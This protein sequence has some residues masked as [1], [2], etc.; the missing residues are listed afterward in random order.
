MRIL[1]TGAAGFIGRMVVEALAARDDLVVDGQPGQIA[2]IIATDI[3]AGPLADLSARHDQVCAIPGSLDDPDVLARIR[4]N[5][6]DVIVHLAAVV[7]GLAEQDFDLGMRV[8]VHSTIALIDACRAMSHPPV[9]LFSSSV[10]VF[11]CPGNDTI[12]ETT[13]PA[14]MS[15]Y[16]T[17]KLI[18]ELLV[19]DASRKGFIKGRAIRFPTISVRPGKPNR[20]ASSFASGIIREPLAGM[21][22]DLPV[23]HDLRLHLASPLKALDGILVAIGLSQ[24]TIGVETTLT[25]PGTSVTVAGMIE[26]L[27]RLAGPQCAALITP[28]PDPAIERIV[29]SWPGQILSPRAESL[30]FSANANIEEIIQ[31]YM[32]GSQQAGR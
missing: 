32:D 3:A 16:G 6:P 29:A 4:E 1:V 18:C 21:R 10:A 5:A 24:D 25:L 26:A 27:S 23:G 8:N 13:L 17:Q 31:E 30:G 28:R 15:S 9:F 19:R 20:A 2:S 14:P 11:S 22:A 7:S 12:S